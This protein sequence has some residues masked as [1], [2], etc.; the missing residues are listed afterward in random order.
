MR[1][2]LGGHTYEDV[3]LHAAEYADGSV[4]LTLS[5][6]NGPLATATVRL[7]HESPAPGCVWI[8]DYAE[9]EGMLASLTEAGV[10]SPTGRYAQAGFTHVPEARLL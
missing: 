7:V 1:V 3:H 2:T 5:D 10:V 4:A 8:K 9:C 6:V